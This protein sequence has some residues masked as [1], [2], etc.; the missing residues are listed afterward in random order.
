MT[1]PQGL[2]QRSSLDFAGNALIRGL[3]IRKLA[4][5]DGATRE[6]LALV[7]GT[8]PSG[9]RAV[10]ELQVIIALRERPAVDD[11]QRQRRR[12]EGAK[13]RLSRTA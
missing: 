9:A 11:R 6:C 8:W 12:A 3:R 10:R 7:V 2:S 1:L 5:G 4:V 13:C